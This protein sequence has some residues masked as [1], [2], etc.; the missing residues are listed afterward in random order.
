MSHVSFETTKVKELEGGDKTLEVKE[1]GQGDSGC[2]AS[3]W[4]QSSIGC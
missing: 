3:P 2:V 1:K 4:V